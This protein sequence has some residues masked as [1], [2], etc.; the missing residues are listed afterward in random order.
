MS[1][2]LQIGAI[3]R[4]LYYYFLFN[5]REDRQVF[6]TYLM[7]PNVKN[8]DFGEYVCIISKPGNTIQ[9]RVSIR[10]KV[11]DVGAVNP[12]PVPVGKMILV[13][14]VIFFI[15]LVMVVLYL[16]YGLKL[17]VRIK[18]SFSGLEEN[19]GKINDVLIV[20]SQ[21]TPK[22][23]V[24][25]CR[26]WKTITVTNVVPG[27]CQPHQI[28]VRYSDLHDDAQKCRR[29]IALISPAVVNEHWDA[30]SI[31]Q[32]LKQ[33]QS[34]GPKFVCVALKE[35]PKNQNEVKNSQ[36]ETLASLSR[37]VGVIFW[38]RKNEA[39]FWYALRLSLPPKR[40]TEIVENRNATQGEN[41]SRLTSNSEES[42]YNL[43]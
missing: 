5:F 26:L 38:E 21:K 27:H 29:I 23:L 2:N 20:H 19:D 17:Q 22:S 12:N 34:L 41:N 10:E 40:R 31:L 32:A 33:L 15:I 24:S 4:L 36:G 16:Q 35:L 25:S 1:C 11:K 18:D 42:L 6:G 9:R 14:S 28:C 13:M 3:K 37:S 7:I 39:K 30:S 43:V 8:E